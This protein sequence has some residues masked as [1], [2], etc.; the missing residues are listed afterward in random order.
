[1]RCRLFGL[2]E[3][4]REPTAE[5]RTEGWYACSDDDEVCLDRS[6]YP[7]DEGSLAR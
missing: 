1:M 4:R 2:W 5:E 3:G 7:D 6:C